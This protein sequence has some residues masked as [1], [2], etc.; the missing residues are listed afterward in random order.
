M[1]H[2]WTPYEAL[3]VARDATAAEI[4]A[5]YKRKAAV[6]H[7]DRG[8]G[9]EEF[10]KLNGAYQLLS[11]PAR[12]E[13]YD[14]TGSTEGFVDEDAV[15]RNQVAQLV[16]NLIEQ[17]PDGANIIEH[18]H[19]HI[20]NQIASANAEMKQINKAIAKRERATRLLVKKRG[21][22]ADFIR[23][24]VDAEIEKLKHAVGVTIPQGIERAPTGRSPSW[25]STTVPRPATRLRM[26]GAP[27]ELAKYLRGVVA[28][29][30]R[31]SLR[32]NK[33]LVMAL[34]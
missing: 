9:T 22:G 1:N 11:D 8:G 24:A 6:L 31:Q 2:A 14:R 23:M 7:P 28:H 17:L 32:F 5:A 13:A 25:A 33:C 10:Q 15:I 21:A 30:V 4:K 34:G 29:F 20:K 18:A 26:S 19:S 12:R 27:C 3:G 16:L